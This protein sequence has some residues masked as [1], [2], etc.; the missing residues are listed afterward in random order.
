MDSATHIVAYYSALVLGG[1]DFMESSF[2]L[3]TVTTIDT[4]CRVKMWIFDQSDGSARLLRNRGGHSAPPT[5][6]RFCS[7]G[8]DAIKFLSGGK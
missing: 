3:C 6:I 1:S 5:R 2:L 8:G 7:T 4:C